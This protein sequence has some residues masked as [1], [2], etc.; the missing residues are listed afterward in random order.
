M[1]IP[2]TLISRGY[3]DNV[4]DTNVEASVDRDV[5]NGIEVGVDKG[6]EGYVDKGF[7]ISLDSCLLNNWT[8]I[9]ATTRLTA[10]T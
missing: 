2:L 8:V 10:Y 4:I 5:D 7:D 6:V 3:V 1:L 9:F